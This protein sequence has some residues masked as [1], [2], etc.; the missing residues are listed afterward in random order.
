MN[1]NQVQKVAQQQCACTWF[2]PLYKIQVDEELKSKDITTMLLLFPSS[3]L[4]TPT[5]PFLFKQSLCSS[6]YSLSLSS[7]G[8]LLIYEC[9]NVF[10]YACLSLSPKISISKIILFVLSWQQNYGEAQE[11]QNSRQIPSMCICY[12]KTHFPK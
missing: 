1:L 8:S 5:H 12:F 6:R 7:F 3:A 10:I 9:V 2:L 11:M 4:T